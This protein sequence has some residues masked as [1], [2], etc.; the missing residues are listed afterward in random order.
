M[1]ELIEG[2]TFLDG[3]ARCFPA[4]SVDA[5]SHRI[6]FDAI[7]EA[8]RVDVGET[9][10]AST[11]DGDEPIIRLKKAGILSHNNLQAVPTS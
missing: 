11:S 6:I 8:Y 10:A 2:G 5:N 1:E 7:V 3:L 9:R 4:R